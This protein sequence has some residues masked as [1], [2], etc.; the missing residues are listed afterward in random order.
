M[1][2]TKII[3]LLILIFNINQKIQYCTID[4]KN[5]KKQINKIINK[6]TEEYVRVR[7]LTE[8]YKKKLE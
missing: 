5:S 8:Y 3:M 6:P 7:A 2:Q 4:F 1:I